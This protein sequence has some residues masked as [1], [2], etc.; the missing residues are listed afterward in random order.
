[1]GGGSKE[2]AYVTATCTSGGYGLAFM[3]PNGISVT[4]GTGTFQV[5][6][7]SIC[8]IG[9]GARVTGGA[10]AILDMPYGQMGYEVTGDF[11][12]SLGEPTISKRR[13]KL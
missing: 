3:S 2:E 11:E 12:I 5:L 9:A 4:M 6:K 7:N 8:T 10:K 13:N 1:M